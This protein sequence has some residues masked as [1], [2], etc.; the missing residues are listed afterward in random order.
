M[1]NMVLSILLLLSWVL[2]VSAQEEKYDLVAIMILDHMSD[3]IGDLTSA[4]F[5]V[6]SSI[7]ADDPDVGFNTHFS[8]SQ[9]YFDGPDKM[10]AY[11]DGD[12][13]KRGFWYNGTRL[14]Y[15]SFDENNYAAISTPPTT[16][17]TI[18]TVNKSYGID[19]PAADFFYPTFTDDLMSQSDQIIFN[20]KKTVAGKECFQ[21]IS[22]S[23]AMT[24][25]IWIANDALNLPVKYLISRH[26]KG[27]STQYEGTFSNWQINPVLPA[28]MFEFIPPPKARAISIMPR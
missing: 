3:V 11:V 5:T 28:S 7:D 8:E 15:Y 14:I 19:F 18:D 27:T 6:Q 23:N 22:K 24:I 9:V 25:Q 17:E 21:I 20:G 2:P 10:L 26:D 13:G 4:S 1:K 16:I 12:K